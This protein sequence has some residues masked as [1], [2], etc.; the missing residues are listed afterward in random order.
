MAG[1]TLKDVEGKLAAIAGAR[2]AA[3]DREGPP[4]RWLEACREVLSGK[5]TSFIHDDDAEWDIFTLTSI[6]QA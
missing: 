5:M 3:D 4:T 2:A 6:M 1:Q